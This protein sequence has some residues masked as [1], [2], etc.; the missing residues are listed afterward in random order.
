MCENWNDRKSIHLHNNLTITAVGF[1]NIYGTCFSKIINTTEKKN[2]VC[3]K[4][5]GI[6]LMVMR[7]K[8]KLLKCGSMGLQFIR[9]YRFPWGEVGDRYSAHWFMLIFLLSFIL[10]AFFQRSR[11]SP[12]G[13]VLPAPMYSPDVGFAQE[14]KTEMAFASHVR[15]MTTYALSTQADSH[16][17]SH[18]GLP[19]RWL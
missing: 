4:V 5:A 2:H 9:G 11:Y 13:H 6:R 7:G 15:C 19:Q 1:N 14:P 16:F 18:A 8:R 12:W 17:Q 10:F 3:L